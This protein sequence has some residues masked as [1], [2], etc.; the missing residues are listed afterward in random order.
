MNSQRCLSEVELVALWEGLREG[1]L[2][3][4][5][6]A[7]P[8]IASHDGW[9]RAKR[10]ARARLGAEAHNGVG[11][12][13]RTMAEPDIR[14]E[15]FGWNDRAPKNSEAPIRLLGVRKDAHGFLVEQLPGES[16]WHSGGFAIAEC[17][18]VEL[19]RALAQHLP[20]VGPGRLGDVVLTGDG[21]CDDAAYDYRQSVVAEQTVHR[22]CAA[23]LSAPTCGR[24]VVDIVQGRSLFGPRGITRHRLEWRDVIDD[25]RYVITRDSGPSIA[26]PVGAER[27]IA[28]INSKV[29]AVVRAIKDERG[30]PPSW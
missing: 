21:E 4:P 27:F 24:G 3:A 26:T 22:R 5:L 10:E 13:V 6:M 16:V 7:L 2:P 11:D 9:E 28:M 8:A 18:A 19:A 14:I 30:E 25:G 12:I 15:A 1:A 20:K 29:A 23:F 17:T